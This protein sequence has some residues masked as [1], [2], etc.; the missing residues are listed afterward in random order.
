MDMF[1]CTDFCFDWLGSKFFMVYLSCCFIV[2]STS[3]LNAIVGY[4]FRNLSSRFKWI[5]E[6]VNGSWVLHNYL[7]IEEFHDHLLLQ[8]RRVGKNCEVK[9]VTLKNI[10]HRSHLPFQSEF[11]KSSI[12]PEELQEFQCHLLFPTKKGILFSEK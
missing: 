8:K 10:L 6:N 2:L 3:S 11:K 4:F 12:V 5:K 1:H 7:L 9:W